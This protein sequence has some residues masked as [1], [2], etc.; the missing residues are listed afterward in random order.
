MSASNLYR[1]DSKIDWNALEV[2][3][4]PCPSDG[5]RPSVA[6]RAEGREPFA[7]DLARSAF[8][9]TGVPPGT[10][11]RPRGREW[12]G[13]VRQGRTD[14]REGGPVDVRNAIRTA[15]GREMLLREDDVRVQSAVPVGV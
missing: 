8:D 3:P 15:D 4:G 12:S 9:R 10:P 1:K 2:K 11:A 14:V 13:S 7:R 6:R 5:R